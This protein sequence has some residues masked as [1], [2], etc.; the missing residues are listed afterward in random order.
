MKWTLHRCITCLICMYE[1]NCKNLPMF[2]VL[3]MP[4]KVHEKLYLKHK[5]SDKNISLKNIT[6]SKLFLMIGETKTMSRFNDRKDK[7]GKR[8]LKGNKLKFMARIN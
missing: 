1:F 6:V 5:E 2:V 7:R 8:I 3:I 4:L